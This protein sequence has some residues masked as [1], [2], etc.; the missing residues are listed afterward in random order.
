MLLVA[1]A[2][3]AVASAM[4]ATVLGGDGIAAGMLAATITLTGLALSMVPRPAYLAAGLI[5]F[6]VF[7]V[8]MA[9]L[10]GAG[11]AIWAAALTLAFLVALTA[12][13]AA[14]WMRVDPAAVTAVAAAVMAGFLGAGAFIGMSWVLFGW[15]VLFLCAVTLGAAALPWLRWGVLSATSLGRRGKVKTASPRR[16]KASRSQRRLAVDVSVDPKTARHAQRRVAEALDALPGEFHS[17]HAAH[18]GPDV[19]AVSH[20]VF[21]AHGTFVLGVLPVPDAATV[22]SVMRLESLG[23]DV[24][25]EIAR[26]A[27]QRG[28]VIRRLGLADEAVMAVLVLVTA[29]GDD[30]DSH[31]TIAGR[32]VGTDYEGVHVRVATLTS[33]PGLLDDPLASGRRLAAAAAAAKAAALLAP[34]RRFHPQGETVEAFE[35]GLVDVDGITTWLPPSQMVST[36]TSWAVG[37]Q[38]AVLT[39][40]GAITGQRLVSLPYRV[41][42][43]YVAQ[44]CEERQWAAVQ[45]HMGGETVTVPAAAVQPLSPL[46]R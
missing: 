10:G 27:R 32:P 16:V 7:A 35:V 14:R 40:R 41:N 21:G 22:E 30:L 23:V 44:V 2:A 28:E 33:L 42:G 15:S 43:F 20:L 12:F 36:A 9:M 6:D 11:S 46:P 3:A 31:A 34:S 45:A 39:P 24:G 25:T 29:Q 37:D 19:G 8:G 4:V 13:T 18:A 17:L 26:L 38:V 5:G 1:T